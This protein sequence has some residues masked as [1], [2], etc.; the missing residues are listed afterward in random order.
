MK[1]ILINI[2]I[3]LFSIIGILLIIELFL[4]KID[5]SQPHL[6]RYD[7]EVGVRHME[8]SQGYYIKESKKKVSIN[9]QGIRVPNDNKDFLYSKQK[10]SNV[11]LNKFYI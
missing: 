8:S 5:Y 7:Y 9:P 4:I 10:S 1:N 3:S 2:L 11:F 6:S